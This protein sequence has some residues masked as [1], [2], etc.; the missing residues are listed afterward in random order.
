MIR[1]IVNTITDGVV[2]LFSAGGRSGESFEEREF[3]QDYG[4]ASQPQPG[5]ELIILAAGNT[6]VAIGSDDRRYRLRLE[7]GEAALY[8][9]LG[10]LVHLTRDGI[11]VTSSKKIT[12]S[13]PLVEIVA[14]VKVT[15]TTPLLDVSGSIQANGEI[16]DGKSSMQQMRDIYDGHVHPDP[17]GGSTGPTPA[18]M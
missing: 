4:F 16:S 6:I 9:D 3:I 8:D 18:V 10:Q 17:Q 7:A 5:A 12:A 15:L 14:T 13:A 1:G 2:R 11:V